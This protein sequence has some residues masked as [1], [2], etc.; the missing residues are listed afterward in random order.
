MEIEIEAVERMKMEGWCGDRK[1][2][3]EGKWA[4]ETMLGERK[5]R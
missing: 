1:Q 2:K 4:R 3:K 5:E